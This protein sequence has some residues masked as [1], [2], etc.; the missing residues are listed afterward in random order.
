MRQ[1][2][3]GMSVTKGSVFE[4]SHGSVEVVEFG[5]DVTTS[6]ARFDQLQP[7]TMHGNVGLPISQVSVRTMIQKHRPFQGRV[8]ARGCSDGTKAWKGLG[9]T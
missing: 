9:S 1:D 7:A 6:G 8:V 2:A 3:K 5:R 4:K